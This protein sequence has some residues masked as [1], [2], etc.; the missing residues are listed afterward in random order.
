MKEEEG[1]KLCK[2]LKRDEKREWKWVQQKNMEIDKIAKFVVT[3]KKEF[4][5]EKIV[6]IFKDSWEKSQNNYANTFSQQLRTSQL[7]LY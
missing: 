2:E 5:K 4:K 1:K 3:E 7:K 6:E